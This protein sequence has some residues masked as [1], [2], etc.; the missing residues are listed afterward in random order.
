MKVCPNCNSRNYDA[1]E[2][3]VT[4]GTPIAEAPILQE[5]PMVPPVY[6]QPPF[7]PTIQKRKFRWPDILSLIGFISALLGIFSYSVIL[8]PAALLCSLLG[9]LGDRYKGLAIAGL[10]ISVIVAL[11]KVGMI[12]YQNNLIPDWVSQGIF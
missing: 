8:I 6:V 11:L 9:F 2:F 12:L 7:Y 5:A 10:V 4:C 1:A 3:C